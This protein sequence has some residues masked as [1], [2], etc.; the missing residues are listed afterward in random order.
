MAT[1]ETHERQTGSDYVFQT[2]FDQIVN[3]DL[4]PGT[5]ISETEI[6]KSFGFSRQPIREAF[7]RLA[8]LNLLL[9]RPQRATLVRPFS[10]ELISNARF[11]RAAVELEVIRAFAEDRDRAF[12]TDLKSNM[13]RQRDAI[14]N[15]D[16]KALHDLDYAFH[17]LLCHAARKAFAFDIIAAN[18]AQ[19]DRLCMLSLTSEEAMRTLYEDHNALLEAL[20]AGDADRATQVLK[21]HLDRLT[22]TI[23]A[24]YT[25]HRDYFD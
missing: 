18:K 19:A 13:R 23:N 14:A 9:I 10:M 6:A 8:S 17:K 7:T 3:L 1:V 2:L 11:I 21:S 25:T 22:P 5:K 15:K 24:L 16:T 4:L 20:F 12:D